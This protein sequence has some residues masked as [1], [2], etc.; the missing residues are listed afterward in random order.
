MTKGVLRRKITIK[1]KMATAGGETPSIRKTE[2]RT[3]KPQQ[4]IC[5][6]CGS[7]LG[8]YRRNR[9]QRIHD[10]EV[11]L[12]LIVEIR[13]CYRPS[14]SWYVKGSHQ[15]KD[16]G[17]LHYPEEYGHIAAYNSKATHALLFH[18]AELRYLKKMYLLEIQQHLRQQHAI[19]VDIGTVSN[20]LKLY[21]AA[22]TVLTEEHSDIIREWLQKMPC[23][24][25]LIDATKE[26]SSSPMYRIIEW[27]SGFHLAATVITEE[28]K[29]TLIECL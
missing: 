18:V 14:C 22:C 27:Y 1:E 24:V 2:K 20:W 11:D 29:P 7:L 5:P 8:I 13:A 4:E 16:G 15:P 17:L 25:W 19:H 12:D 21:E 28:V 26:G 9:K 23:R 3:L 6:G 10:L